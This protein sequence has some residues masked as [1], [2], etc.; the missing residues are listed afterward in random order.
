F[1]S[2]GEK[3]A[4]KP[5][6]A[7]NLIDPV[8]DWGKAYQGQQIEHTFTIENNGNS[9]LIIEDIKSHCGCTVP[10]ENE[11]KK[12]LQPGERTSVTI[13]LDTSLLKGAVKKDT[14]VLSNALGDDNKLWMQGEVEELL[15]LAPSM[16][17]VEVVRASTA[18]PSAPTIV[19]VEAKLGK[20]IKISSL[21]PLKGF[22]SASL[23]PVEEG[24]KYEM[25]LTP[26][27][28]KE[29]RT[30]FQTEII[31]AKVE[32]DGKVLPLRLQISV[33]QKE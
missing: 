17:K 11:Y 26:T 7:L 22:L 19:G 3:S 21:T 8:Y 24:K 13:N 20:T 16:P 27:L 32:I 2:D 14:E 4:K 6:P 5:A 10:R 28:K 25:S 18:P 1:G 23:R 15:K 31:E 12:M 29:D 9:P 30:A 33:V